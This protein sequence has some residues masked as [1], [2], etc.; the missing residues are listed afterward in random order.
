V[1]VLLTEAGMHIL[2]TSFVDQAQAVDLQGE[3]SGDPEPEA[4]EE[5]DE[6][7]VRVEDSVSAVVTG[8]KYGFPAPMRDVG[9]PP[10]PDR[11]VADQELRHR[12][13]PLG[14]ATARVA[15]ELH[16]RLDNVSARLARMRAQTGALRIS[17]Q[18]LSDDMIGTLARVAAHL[19]TRPRQGVVEDVAAP[20]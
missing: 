8:R 17:M 12:T 16:A 11:A 13:P 5:D 19:E 6:E 3:D 1:L 9:A 15:E 2:A 4:T 18:A 10:V 7:E 14:P 20:Q